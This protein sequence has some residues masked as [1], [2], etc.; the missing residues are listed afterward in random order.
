MKKG[1]AS[2]YLVY[3]FFLIFIVM[4]LSVLMINN[5]K[6]KFLNTLKTDIKKELTGY[7]LELPKPI[8]NEEKPEE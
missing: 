5:Y 1:F 7:H 6:K 2:M 4:M 8:V 3:S